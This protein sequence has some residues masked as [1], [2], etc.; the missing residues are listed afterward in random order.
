MSQY[1]QNSSTSRAG[2][3]HGSSTG[4]PGDPLGLRDTR[5]SYDPATTGYNPATGAGYS[6]SS[7]GG[8]H[9]HHHQPAS[10]PNGY[11]QTAGQDDRIQ[12]AP[13]TVQR[14]KMEDEIAGGSNQSRSARAGED[15]GKGVKGVAASVHVGFLSTSSHIPCRGSLLTRTRALASHY[16]EHSI[17]L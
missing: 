14:A 8:P 13:S 10:P 5:S 12:H 7:A 17:R 4:A 2:I 1:Q 6:K 11:D 9:Q 15:V 3:S 16:E